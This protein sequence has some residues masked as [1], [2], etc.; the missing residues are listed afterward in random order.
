MSNA[1]QRHETAAADECDIEQEQLI[2]EQMAR[3][4]QVSPQEQEESVAFWAKHL[5]ALD[6]Q[7]R[8]SG[9]MELAPEESDGRLTASVPQGKR[10][11]SHS[12]TSPAMDSVEFME[13]LDQVLSKRLQGSQNEH[14]DG[15]PA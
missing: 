12:A 15:A 13:K 3:Q 14:G 8:A 1:Q 4:S 7:F 10:P 2:A 9:L 6:A 11:Q 5:P